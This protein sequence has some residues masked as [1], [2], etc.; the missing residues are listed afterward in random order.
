LSRSVA[1]QSVKPMLRTLDCGHVLT[2][3]L[4]PPHIGEVLIWPVV[5]ARRPTSQG[6]QG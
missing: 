4:S 3:E 5:S 6:D 1:N 2:F